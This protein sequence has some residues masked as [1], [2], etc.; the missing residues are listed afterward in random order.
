MTT[1]K[2][3]T[4][5][6]SIFSMHMSSVQS[7]ALLLFQA[8]S[9]EQK[10]TTLHAQIPNC[11][12]LCHEA[13]ASQ[14]TLSWD[15]LCKTACS[16]FGCFWKQGN[17][18]VCVQGC[19]FACAYGCGGMGVQEIK[20]SWAPQPAAGSWLEAG[21]GTSSPGRPNPSLGALWNVKMHL[22]PGHCWVN[23]LP[24]QL[25]KLFPHK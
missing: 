7:E 16:A 12:Q 15:Q 19:V 8:T 5:T 2:D 10:Q 14:C 11:T 24:V 18:S 9:P 25:L 22:S 1:F 17:E 6:L 23:G 3:N 20:N 4:F 13:Q 21:K